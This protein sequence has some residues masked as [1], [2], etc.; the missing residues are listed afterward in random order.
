[1]IHSVFIVYLLWGQALWE[2]FRKEK[3][4]IND[5]NVPTLSEI[6]SVFPK[7]FDI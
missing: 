6:I 5:I 1:M 7:I 4:L 2:V 3:N